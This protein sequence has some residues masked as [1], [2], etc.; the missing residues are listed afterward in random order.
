M[1]GDE[2]WVKAAMTDDTIVVEL[3]VR[4]NQ[5]HHPPPPVKQL[6]W[7]VRQ[8]R[9][10]PAAVKPAPR[11]SPTTPLSWSGGATSISGGCGG[12]GGCSGA[13][14]GVREESSHS[15]SPSKLSHHK[16]SK[17][18]NN[19]EKLTIKRSRKKKTLTELKEEEDLL[20]KERRELKREISALRV[21]LEIQ[22]VNNESLKRIKMELQPLPEQGTTIVSEATISGQV[23]EKIA[24]CHPIL[25]ISPPPI[26]CNNTVGLQFATS[27]DSP[28]PKAI[29]APEGKFMLPDLNITFAEESSSEIICEVS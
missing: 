27:D 4:L 1:S 3:L 18:D 7:S 2:E 29:A 20:L 17:V 26:V 24:Y 13:I 28:E 6:K 23:Q 22:R 16:R 14:D 25:P 12:R 10:R 9:S 11:A 15:P 21:N 8:R 5:S 19:S